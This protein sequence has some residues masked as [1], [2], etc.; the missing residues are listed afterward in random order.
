MLSKPSGKSRDSLAAQLLLADD[1]YDA[2]HSRPLI[3][4][5]GAVA[6]IPNTP[7]RASKNTFESQL[8]FEHHLSSSAPPDQRH[9]T[10]SPHASRKTAR[11]YL[12]MVILAA[13]IRRLPVKC[14]RMAVSETPFDGLD[15]S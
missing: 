9:S 12:A 6:V 15:L 10:A 14:V 3:A 2:V 5:R 7:Q 13:T 8:C 1:A 11:T 4:E